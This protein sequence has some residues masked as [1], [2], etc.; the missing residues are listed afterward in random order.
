[1]GHGTFRA[2]FILYQRSTG[3]WVCVDV[4]G[5]RWVRVEVDVMV[6]RGREGGGSGSNFCATPRITK[7]Q[8]RTQAILPPRWK[9]TKMALASVD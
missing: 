7:I 6:V 8:P 4:G 9:S 2:A 3:V 5:R 1:M